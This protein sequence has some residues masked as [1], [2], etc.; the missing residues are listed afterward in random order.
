MNATV[1]PFPHA[2]GHVSIF[3]CTDMGGSW[4][5]SHLSEY[6][7]HGSFYG[8]YFSFAEAEAVAERIAQ[9]LGAAVN[10]GPAT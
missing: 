4:G 3:P 9:Q 8:S 2:G 1:I 6:G 5:V 7:D 10:G